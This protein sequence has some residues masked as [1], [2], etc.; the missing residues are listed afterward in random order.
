MVDAVLAVNLVGCRVRFLLV[1]HSA[2]AVLAANRVGCRAKLLLVVRGAAVACV[3]IRVVCRARDQPRQDQ[4]V[5]TAAHEMHAHRDRRRHNESM[6]VVPVARQANNSYP[7]AADRQGAGD[8]WP[9][10]ARSGL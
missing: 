10:C 2:V 4:R 7:H 1:A 3:V 5:R 6:M 9:S 8:R